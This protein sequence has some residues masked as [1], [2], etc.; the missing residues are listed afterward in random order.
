VDNYYKSPSPQE[1]R[2]RD[3]LDAIRSLGV[4]ASD[5]A[6]EL[7]DAVSQMVRRA[8]DVAVADHDRQMVSS[9]SRQ[10]RQSTTGDAIEELR[11]IEASLDLERKMAAGRS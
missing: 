5:L 9:F 1:Q 6:D 7:D 8:V 2:Y 11:H 4:A 3:V 10:R